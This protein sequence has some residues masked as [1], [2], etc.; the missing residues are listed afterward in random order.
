LE[1][2]TDLAR[3]MVARFGMSARLGR[4]RL[5]S[6]NVDEFLDAEAALAAVSAATH[7]EVDDE[8][9][10]IL[11]ECERQATQRLSAHRA[12]LDVLASTLE[13]EE[14]LEGAELESILAAI[15]PGEAP[16]PAR[17]SANGRAA[18]RAVRTRRR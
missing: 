2:A 3:D 18:K 15:V 5:V 9:R 11:S 8:I 14:T 12:T 4:A 17:V 6:K 16:V 13:R 1:S 10:R 7:E